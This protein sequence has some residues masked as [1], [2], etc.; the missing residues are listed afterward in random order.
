MAQADEIAHSS[1]GDQYFPFFVHDLGAQNCMVE[2]GL[3][4]KSIFLSL[5]GMDLHF[6][7]AGSIEEVSQSQ[8]KFS[9]LLLPNRS[10]LLQQSKGKVQAIGL[11]SLELSLVTVIYL[12]L[13]NYKTV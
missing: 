8:R 13:I 10:F 6:S 12:L 9:A 3:E 4:G 1:R 2:W 7:T 11:E 5:L